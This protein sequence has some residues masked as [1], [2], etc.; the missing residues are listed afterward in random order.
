MEIG[1]NM[2]IVRELYIDSGQILSVEYKDEQ[3]VTLFPGVMGRPLPAHCEVKVELRP[4]EQSRILVEVWLPIQNWNGDFLGTGNGG[5]AGNIVALELAN[6]LRRG[7]ATANTDM[8]TEPDIDKLI[9]CPERWK[10]FGYRA[11]HLM[12]VVGKQIT[13]AFYGEAIGTSLFIGG[14]TGGQQALSEAQRYPEDYNGIL[15]IAPA[16]YRTHLHYGFIWN[17]MALHKC[18]D[19]GFAQEAAQLVTDH[20]LKKYG[21][22]G[23]CLPGDRFFTCPQ[24]IDLDSA[25]FDDCEGLTEGQK[26]ALKMLSQAPKN[27]VTGEKIYPAV[28]TPGSEAVDLGLVTQS[29]LQQ[30]EKDFLYL[31]RWLAGKDYDFT[32]FDFNKDVAYFDHVLGD[33][34]NATSV[35]L[36]Q[37]RELGGKL[38]MLHGMADPIIPYTDSQQYYEQVVH[39]DGGIEKTRAYFRYFQIPGLG[40]IAGGPGVQDI[41]SH[42]FQATPQDTDHDSLVALSKWVKTGKAPERLLAVA[43]KDGNILNGILYDHFE[44]ERPC[45]AY[46]YD[47]EFVGTDPNNPNHYA[48]REY[49]K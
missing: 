28:Y 14:S 48:A 44:Y 25:V 20:L 46:P 26:E 32:T 45:F 27:P 49:I 41:T 15:A 23:C 17:W 31:F 7:Y 33:I 13:E 3:A 18:A 1:K 11:T 9:G 22:Q 37:F 4:V 6:G 39:T 34:L 40:H 38:L 10:D 12:T 2:Q 8:G 29:N 21:N 24:F 43:F 19:T 35:D 30:F 5:S 47:A 42:G 16:Y 36:S